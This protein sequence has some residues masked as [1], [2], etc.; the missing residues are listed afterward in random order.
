[1]FQSTPASLTSQNHQLPLLT[2]TLLQ[3]LMEINQGSTLL[4]RMVQA[5]NM[6]ALLRNEKK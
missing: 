6:K 3:I 2:K 4:R 1:M 5:I